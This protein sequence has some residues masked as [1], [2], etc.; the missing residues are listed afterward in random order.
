MIK[1]YNELKA[2]VEKG[3]DP[4]VLY[5]NGD[6]SIV[7]NYKKLHESVVHWI[8]KDQQWEYHNLFSV[9]FESINHS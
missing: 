8:G 2:T 1:T 4:N 3:G 7:E 9:Y 5:E 6:L